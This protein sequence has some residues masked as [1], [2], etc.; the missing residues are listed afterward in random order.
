MKRLIRNWIMALLF[1]IT[2]GGSLGAVA[3]PQ[4]TFAACN[5]HLLTF[6][7]WY[8]GLTDGD[9]NIVNPTTAGGL[10][11]FIWSIAL[12]VIEDMMQL[13]GYISVGFII[14]GGFTYMTSTGTPDGAARARKTIT[15]AIVGLV[16]SVFSVAIVNLVAGAV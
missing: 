6:P 13:V 4:T 10:P 16:I 7:A 1:V 5:D 15:N 8:R 12:N 11:K 3:L 14:A 2:F 9:C